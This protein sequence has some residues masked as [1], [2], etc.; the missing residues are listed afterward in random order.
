MSRRRHPTGGALHH[1]R[2]TSSLVIGWRR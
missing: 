2:S 1:P